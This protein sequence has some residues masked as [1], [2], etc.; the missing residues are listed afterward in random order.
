MK[1]LIVGFSVVAVLAGCFIVN[2]SENNEI[3]TKTSD[4]SGGLIADRSGGLIA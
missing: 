3:S 1:K 2:N 4:R